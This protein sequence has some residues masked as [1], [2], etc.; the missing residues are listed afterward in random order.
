MKKQDEK[1]DTIPFSE[2]ED[3]LRS[4]VDEHKYEDALIYYDETILK[5]DHDHGDPCSSY[6]FR[7]MGVCRFMDIKDTWEQ[8]G[9]QSSKWMEIG[10]DHFVGGNYKAAISA[11]DKAILENG[12]DDAAWYAMGCAYRALGN[13]YESV[14][15]W[16]EAIKIVRKKRGE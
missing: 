2:F 12:E 7:I 8:Q 10:N 5:T 14:E 16:D 11:Y 13:P 3:H 9:R 4:L 1:K 15:A 6:S